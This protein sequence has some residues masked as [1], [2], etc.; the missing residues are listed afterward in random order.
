MRGGID[1]L[2]RDKAVWADN[3]MLLQEDKKA[4]RMKVIFSLIVTI[5]LAVIFHCVYRS[6]PSR[7]TIVYHPVTQITTTLYLIL[8]LVIL[9]KANRQISKS[10]IK[11][12]DAQEAKMSEYFQMVSEFDE[13][14]KQKPAWF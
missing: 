3:V 5:L 10:W 2:L 14:R 11:P 6:M 9:R 4:A 7:Y 13:K 8:N 12:V 1:L